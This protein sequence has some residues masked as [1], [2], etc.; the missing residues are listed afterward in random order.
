MGVVARDEKVILPIEWTDAWGNH[1][2]AVTGN[3]VAIHAMR[4]LA[5]HSNGFQTV[6]ALSTLMMT[7]GIIDRP[8][9]FRHKPPYPRPIP[10]CPKTINAPAPIKPNSPLPNPELGFPATPED[11]MVNPDGTPVRIDKAYSWEFPLTAHGMMQNVITNAYKG[12]PYKIDTL[13]FFMANMAWN[14]SMNTSAMIEMLKGREQDGSYKIPFLVVSYAFF[15][16]TVAF[17]DLVLP[18]TTYLERYDVLSLLD[19]PISEFSSIVDS[20]RQPVL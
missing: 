7:L 20:I 3:P 18:D 8:G 2:A 13:I 17:A 1:H 10:P 4:G 5:A 11:L 19:R 15:S 12:D 14:S 16:E 6:R 9:G